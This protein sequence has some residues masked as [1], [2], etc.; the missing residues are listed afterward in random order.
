MKGI[1]LAGG[2]GSRLFPL[3]KGL[4][5]HLLPIFDKPMIYYSLSVLLLSGIN[6][7]LIICRPKDMLQYKSVF[8]QFSEFDIKFEF[9]EQEEPRGIPEAFIIG[10]EFIN[11]EPVALILGDNFFYGTGLSP[12][13]EKLSG[14]RHGASVIGYQVHNPSQFGVI[15]LNENGKLISIEEKPN[16]PKSNFAATG[17][18]FFDRKVCESAASVEPSSRGELEIVDIIQSYVNNS[19][20][21]V[22]ILGRGFC[23]FDTGTVSDLFEAANFV[24]TTQKTQGFL[25]GCI[26]EIALNKN[27]ATKEDLKILLRTR[28]NNDYNNYLRDLV[29]Q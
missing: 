11:N 23:W 1:I 22:E 17:L 7:I 16:D 29:G 15:E 24:R 3:T 9:A 19:E 28:P 12:I 6:E 2:T 13:L 4:S 20:V 27:W 21:F 10:K 8:D 14:L 26:E 5:K 25:I 18:Y